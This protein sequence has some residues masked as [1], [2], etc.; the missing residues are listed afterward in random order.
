MET[1]PT[2]R[3]IYAEW[4]MDGVVVTFSDGNSAIYSAALL[5][6]SFPEAKRISNEEEPAA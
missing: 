3:I 6:A 5:Y 2:P 1:S 4:L